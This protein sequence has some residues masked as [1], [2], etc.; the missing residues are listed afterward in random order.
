MNAC[1]YL[2]RVGYDYLIDMA[3]G[4]TLP[5]DED[6]PDACAE[7]VAR[8]DERIRDRM[9]AA[10][11]AQYKNTAGVSWIIPI[12]WPDRVPGLV[13]WAGRMTLCSIIE[14]RV[15]SLPVAGP[16]DLMEYEATLVSAAE[17]AAKPKSQ[18]KDAIP[19][20]SGLDSRSC[21][22]SLDAGY[23]LRDL[24]IPIIIRPALEL[25][26]IIGLETLPL[27]SYGPRE[28][29]FLHRGRAWRFT[30]HPRSGGYYHYWGDVHEEAIR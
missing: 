7:A 19:G 26:A 24:G 9:R 8:D 21:V 1:E 30:C 22:G 18:V 12:T 13:T 15:A 5:W 16:I 29:G 4:P 23:S 6:D 25:L 14:R 2:A 3:S 20:M 28:C 11:L 10:T 27:I 17:L